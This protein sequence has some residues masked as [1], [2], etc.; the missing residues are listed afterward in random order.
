M[1]AL[2]SVEDISNM[3]GKLENIKVTP[4]I[5][6]KDI[7]SEII[8]VIFMPYFQD[9]L[10]HLQDLI[11]I[12]RTSK[13]NSKVFQKYINDL[14]VAYY[15]KKQY[16]N[17]AVHHV[18]TY[19]D[20]KSLEI[21]LK[22]DEKLNLNELGFSPPYYNHWD[23]GP[24]YNTP[25]GIAVSHNYYKMIHF[26]LSRNVDINRGNQK[27]KTPL[28]IA[29]KHGFLHVVKL[30]LKQENIDIFISENCYNVSPL[31]I[32]TKYG[33]YDIVS[34]LLNHSS[35]T[36]AGI[37]QCDI[38]GK[39]PLDAAEAGRGA[40]IVASENLKILLRSHGAVLGNG[41][42]RPAYRNFLMV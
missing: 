30:L 33:H 17:N 34:S 31:F 8:I 20:Y 19:N 7:P 36:L 13:L 40:A 39:T 27:N 10:N 41:Y 24:E 23:C 4:S 2:L 5:S 1:A 26:L 25:L 16:G 6:F 3:T 28:Y 15:A 9:T 38:R 18:V 22:S 35:M 42:A 37:N 29:C 21:L 12:S 14:K 32:A 11:A